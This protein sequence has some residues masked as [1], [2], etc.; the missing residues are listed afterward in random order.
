MKG[1]IPVKPKKRGR[2]ATGTDPFIGVR[3]PPDLIKEI[4]V[5]AANATS[6]DSRSEAIRELIRLGLRAKGGKR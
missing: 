2:P 4:D 5:W 1:S 6:V 3:L